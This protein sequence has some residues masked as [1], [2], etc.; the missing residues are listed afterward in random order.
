MNILFLNDNSAHVNWGAQATPPSLIKILREAMPECQIK[1][2]SHKWLA[3]RYQY[4]LHPLF[5]G[6]I[7]REPLCCR[8]FR[9]ILLRSSK[10]FE[11]YPEIVDDFD[12]YCD[13]WISDQSGPHAKEFLDLA[14]NADLVIYN[15]ENS[16]YRNT[17]EGCH[18]I[19]LLYLAKTRLRKTACIVNH[20]AHL[21][22]VRPI[23]AGMAQKVYPILDLVAVREKAS[24]E[25]LNQM[26]IGNVRLF[27]DVAFSQV[28]EDYSEDTVKIWLKQNGLQNQSYFCVS[29]SGLP[30]SM[31]NGSY[32]GQMTE[33]VKK[34]KETGLQ[35]VLVAKDPW[36]L[37]LEE[38]AKRTNSLFFGPNHE[39]YDLW[40]LFKNASF[41]VTGH[42]HYAI[43]A[44]MMGCP[45]VPLSVNNHKM[46]GF[47]SML[48]WHLVNPFDVTYLSSCTSNIFREVQY[49]LDNRVERS[50]FLFAQS[51]KFNRQTFELGTL[52]QQA[53]SKS[54][55]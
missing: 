49:L 32:D 37:P 12:F 2:L 18:G 23:L 31:P 14:K 11:F 34:L 4:K 55:T 42:Y 50:E 28:P 40:P 46:K 8:V 7:I 24:L 36:C 35:A 52:V 22:D 41:L 13:K 33:L 27:P 17:P 54:R 20:T 25:N 29:A 5:S 43:F 19:F 3:R 44:T 16:I 48:E 15:G 9:S 39:F 6:R 51:R 53:V 26:H 45:F 21:N 1:A 47:C 38:V 10:L 30:V